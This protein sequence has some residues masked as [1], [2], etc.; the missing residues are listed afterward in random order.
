MTE[1][2]DKHFIS[3]YLKGQCTPQEVEA[4]DA[5]LKDPSNSATVHWMREVWETSEADSKQL[6]GVEDRIL[7]N[8]EKRIANHPPMSANEDQSSNFR[9]PLSEMWQHY[10]M[11]RYASVILIVL[12][13][14]MII[15]AMMVEPEIVAQIEYLKKETHNGQ[16][17]TFRLEDGTEVT[18]NSN[19][20]LEFPATFSDSSRIV[21]LT[22]EAFFDVSKDAK[23]PFTVYSGSV[24]T[25]ALGTSFNIEHFPTDPDISVSL[26]S[27]AVQVN[28]NQSQEELI[29]KPGC[30]LVFQKESKEHIIQPFDALLAT[31]WKDG[32]IYFE[33]SGIDE[34]VNRL[35]VWYDVEIHVEGDRDRLKSEDWT[36]TGKFDNELLENVLLGIGHTEGFT[37][38]FEDKKQVVLYLN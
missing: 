12:I 1:K 36:Y 17:L 22:G 21:T 2:F 23:R 34:I 4:F 16:H 28:L 5:F 6:L 20:S 18:L 25:T 26:V 38:R 9:I 19:S 29:L 27:G 7:S 33:S 32:I 24:A 31:G 30:Q 14:L 11:L 13:P 10:P 8:I 35:N 3:K 15:S 37:F